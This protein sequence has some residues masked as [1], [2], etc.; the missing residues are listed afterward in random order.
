MVFIFFQ[1]SLEANEAFNE[2]DRVSKFDHS[3]LI[4]AKENAL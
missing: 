3:L 4:G 2:I 1:E